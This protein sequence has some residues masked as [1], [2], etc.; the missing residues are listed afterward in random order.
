MTN[1]QERYITTEFANL[2]HKHEKAIEHLNHLKEIPDADPAR[3][4]RYEKWTSELSGQIE[5]FHT[6][7]YAL[8]LHLQYHN[9]V[10][11]NDDLKE[12]WTL[13]IR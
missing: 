11:V 10:M 7:L 5:G 1:A 2:V 9:E 8:G 12:W 6:V 13:E 4:E 3:I